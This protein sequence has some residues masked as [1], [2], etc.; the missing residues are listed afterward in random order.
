MIKIHLGNKNKIV[1]VG[2][3]KDRR[4]LEILLKHNWYR[5]PLK[6]APARSFRY[7]AFYQP[8]SFGRDG[9]RIK[10][11]AR[12]LDYKIAKRSDLLRNELNHPRA[13]DYYLR[14]LVDKI[15]KLPEPIRNKIPRRISFGFTTLKR[16]LESKD[17][18]QVYGVLPA[19]EVIQKALKR[20]VIQVTP[21]YHVS[22]GG[23]RY[24][25]DFAVFCKLGSIAVECDNRKAHSGKHAQEKDRAKNVNLRRHGWLV[26]RLREKDIVANLN[27][28][29]QKVRKAIQELGGAV[30]NRK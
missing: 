16:L 19:E 20:A 30:N 11:Y 13:N 15:R 26:I 9:K 23:K 10:Y 4:D 8:A 25:L 3:L 17:I 6:H 27:G 18:L 14:F 7:F 12:V 22:V 1:L 21:Q 24:C 29:I 28:C 5:I 2:V